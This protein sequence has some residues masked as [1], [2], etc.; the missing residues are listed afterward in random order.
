MSLDIREKPFK[1]KATSTL[2]SLTVGQGSQASRRGDQ[3][4][5]MSEC[6]NFSGTI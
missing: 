4:A 6:P 5:A 1:R 3:S 2:N